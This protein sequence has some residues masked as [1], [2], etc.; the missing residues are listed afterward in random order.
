MGWVTEPLLNWERRLWGVIG[1]FWSGYSCCVTIMTRGV[2]LAMTTDGWIFVLGSVGGFC[3][4]FAYVPQ[5][6]KIWKQGG[7]DLSYG[8]LGL[9]W[10]GV[11]LWLAYGLLLHAQAVVVTN[12]ATAIL[13][14]IA[15]ALKAWTA[16]RNEIKPGLSGV[17]TE[18]N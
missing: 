18:G 12:L 6:I 8:M 5:V 17:A 9:Y 10:F 1:D 11:V 2:R 16:R 4:T 14:A 13:I 15:T 3:T 7:R